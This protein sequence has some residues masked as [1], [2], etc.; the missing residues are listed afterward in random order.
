LIELQIALQIGTKPTHWQWIALFE[1][2]AA[3]VLVG[4]LAAASLMWQ[5]WGILSGREHYDDGTRQPLLDSEMQVG[6]SDRFKWFPGG[7]GR[8][9]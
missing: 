3:M 5:Y 2:A 8:H 1:I 9:R 4:M 7:G 6:V